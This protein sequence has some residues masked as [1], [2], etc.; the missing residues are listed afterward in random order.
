[1]QSLTWNRIEPQKVV[2]SESFLELP[3][4]LRET[5]NV[6]RNVPGIPAMIGSKLSPAY[7]STLYSASLH[8]KVRAGAVRG[9][10]ESMVDLSDNADLMGKFLGLKCPRMFMYGDQNSSLSYLAD[11]KAKGV[12]LAEIKAC[13]HFP[14]YSN[15]LEM[16]QQ[17][18]AFQ[19]GCLDG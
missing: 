8:H 6:L 3:Q 1:M 18:S 15:P 10:F 19:A 2:L 13:G 17:I 7:A 11:I 9:I 4:H 14:M 12:Q 16:W 5:F